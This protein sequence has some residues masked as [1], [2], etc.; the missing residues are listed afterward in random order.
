MRRA[1][2]FLLM[3]ALIVPAVAEAQF[4]ITVRQGD[5]SWVTPGDG[6]TSV[7]FNSPDLPPLPAG[8]FGP[9]SLPYN[10]TVTFRGNP[11]GTNPPGAL[12]NA[13]TL[14][15]RLVDA[16][17]FFF[18]DS[19]TVPIQIRGLS[20][21]SQVPI[22]V[23]FSSGGTQ[24]WN[25]KLSLSTLAPQPIGNMT[26]TLQCNDGGRFTSTLPVLPRFIFTRGAATRILDC[27]TGACNATNLLSTNGCWQ[28]LYP[29]SPFRAAVCNVSPL[30]PGVNV[31]GNCD[32][33]FDYLTIGRR[34]FLAGFDG[35]ATPAGCQRC[36]LVERHP[37]G[38]VHSVVGPTGCQDGPVIS[39]TSSSETNPFPEEQSDVICPQPTGT[40]DPG[41][42]VGG[43]EVAGETQNDP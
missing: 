4:P 19:D 32:M 9:G 29:G 11:L 28:R 20:L 2:L 38:A 13:D 14:V 12:G 3:A 16:T 37:E 8:F 42:T 24:Q 30:P 33:A 10:G 27:G 6:S 5:D 43:T 36:V 41:T 26:I 22:T 34:D 39:N 1:L 40:S 7:T 25:V 23:S 17:F 35:C 15:R 18:G 31:D 21:V